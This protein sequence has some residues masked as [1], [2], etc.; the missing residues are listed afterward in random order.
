RVFLI[1][2]DEDH[3]LLIRKILERA[4]HAVTRCR[5]AADAL[6]VLGD[7]EYDLVLLDQDLP[8]MPRLDLL[9]AM[10]REGIATP[11]LMIAGKGNRPPARGFLMADGLDYGAE[12]YTDLPQRVRE[13]VTRHRL[14]HNNR[15][16]VSAL[17]SARDGM[18]I[19]DLQG[20]IV[21]VNQAL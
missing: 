7:G 19:T 14:P 15:L 18:M 12:F 6:S 3:A 9:R 2:D 16:L 4:G 17:E 8:D 11:A 21:R 5:T 20:T 13:A 1:E 10:A